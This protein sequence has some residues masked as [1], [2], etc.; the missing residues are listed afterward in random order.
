MFTLRAALALT[1]ALTR[2]SDRPE[3]VTDEIWTEAVRHYDEQALAR[4]IVA[5]ANINVWNRLRPC[6]NPVPEHYLQKRFA[7]LPSGCSVAMSGMRRR[8]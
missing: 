2:L 4:L 7:A 6:E 5:I 8:Q 3:T 1:E